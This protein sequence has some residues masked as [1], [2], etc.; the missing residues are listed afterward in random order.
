MPDH[1]CTSCVWSASTEP[2]DEA[3]HYC[4]E[5]GCE[6]EISIDVGGLESKETVS[7]TI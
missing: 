3:F 7:D 1:N 6:T 4:P 2:T 5:C